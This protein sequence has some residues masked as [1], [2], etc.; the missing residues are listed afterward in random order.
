MLTLGGVAKYTC[1]NFK[2]TFFIKLLT[3]G[4]IYRRARLPMDVKYPQCGCKNVKPG[5]LSKLLY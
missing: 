4:Y 2:K 5:L 1:Q 3:G